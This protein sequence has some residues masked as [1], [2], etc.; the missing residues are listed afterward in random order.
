M[1]IKTIMENIETL[2][3]ENMTEDYIHHDDWPNREWEYVESIMQTLM[4]KYEVEEIEYKQDIPGFEGTK[5]ALDK[6]TI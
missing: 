5:E 1:D 3:A 2:A 4:E 6:I